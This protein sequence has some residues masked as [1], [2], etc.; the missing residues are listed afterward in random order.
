[1]ADDP[2]DDAG[3]GLAPRAIYSQGV[4]RVARQDKE[5]GYGFASLRLVSSCSRVEVLNVRQCLAVSAQQRVADG[6]DH[7]A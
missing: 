2:V 1:M 5:S 6:V 3:P 4:G 7:A